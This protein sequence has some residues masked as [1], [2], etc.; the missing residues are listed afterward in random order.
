MTVD[1]PRH[2]A[3]RAASDRLYQV[4]ANLVEN[5]IKYG[6]GAP[7]DV[8]A[9]PWGPGVRIRVADHGP[10]IPLEDRDRVFE[11]FVQLEHAETRTCGG[12]GLGLAI[13]KEIVERLSGSLTVSE[14]EGGGATFDL[15]L[16][17]RPRA[18]NPVEDTKE[19]VLT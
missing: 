2:L 1:V 7:V 12:S 9:E 17:E 11:R 13:A 6:D 4:V 14:T 15:V 8:T 3:V 10:G 5:A 19:E 18:Q 16:P